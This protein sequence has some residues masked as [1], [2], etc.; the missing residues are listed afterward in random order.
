[1]DKE[2]LLEVYE[3]LK[4]QY[5]L[6]IQKIAEYELI[7]ESIKDVKGEKDTYV[8]IGG[9]IFVKA[10]I[11]EVD[12]LLVNVGD[13][14]FIKKSR[15]DVIKTIEDSIR[16]SKTLKEDIEKQL[17]EIKNKLKSP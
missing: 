10:D 11:K 3:Q 15:E 16:N 7:K 9:M 5:D 8:N 2:E 4:A 13:N 17:E 1:M 12:E 6:I 14:V